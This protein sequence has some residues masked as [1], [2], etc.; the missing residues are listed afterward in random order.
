MGI[1]LKCLFDRP[2]NGSKPYFTLISA[3][4]VHGKMSAITSNLMLSIVSCE[5]M[6][7]HPSATDPITCFKALCFHDLV[8]YS[9]TAQVLTVIADSDD[10]STENPT[11][12]RLAAPPSPI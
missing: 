5:C 10:V 12:T 4:K 7:G 3:Q 2:Q 11:V 6:S 9:F 1:C 8:F